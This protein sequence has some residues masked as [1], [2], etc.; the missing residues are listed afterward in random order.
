VAQCITIVLKKLESS[1]YLNL[2]LHNASS[3]PY[4]AYNKDSELTEGVQRRTTE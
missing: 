3:L 1:Q 2:H 4:L